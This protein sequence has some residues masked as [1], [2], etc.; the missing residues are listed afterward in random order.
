MNTE[1]YL[2]LHRAA[3]RLEKPGTWTQFVRARDV[4]DFP[5]EPTDK[6]AV[7]FCTV[8]AILAESDKNSWWQ[9]IEQE[10]GLAVH[11]A[12]TEAVYPETSIQYWNDCEGR[13]QK[14]V[15]AT[16]RRA[17]NSL[18]PAPAERVLEPA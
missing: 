7:S 6:K 18:L 17:A 3:D 11:K 13:T 15:V 10:V 1:A 14:E 16:I 9:M 8:G 2:L 12:L 4:F 5:I